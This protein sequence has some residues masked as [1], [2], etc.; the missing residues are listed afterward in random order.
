[1]SSS[2]NF[3]EEYLCCR[4]E[5]ATSVVDMWAKRLMWRTWPLENLLL[6]WSNCFEDF[7]WRKVTATNGSRRESEDVVS[8]RHSSFIYLSHRT[9]ILLRMITCRQWMLFFGS[10]R[11]ISNWGVS[12]TYSIR[13]VTVVL[14]FWP[15][16][17]CHSSI[18][19]S[20]CPNWPFP[21]KE[22]YG[23]N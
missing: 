3:T 15:L 9:P 16:D 2:R 1:M 5:W 19:C 20:T 10:R 7:V 21:F 14:N 8:F 13:N 12:I 23:Y 17:S 6:S 18:G 11:Y 4:E 22:G